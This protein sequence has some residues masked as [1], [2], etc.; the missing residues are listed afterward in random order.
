M[1]PEFLDNSISF[2]IHRTAMLLR[3]ELVR[4]LSDYHMTPEQWQVMATLWSTGDPLNQQDIVK[5]T[6]SDKHTV[7]RM[8]GRLEKNGWIKKITSPDDARVT[9]IK[10]TKKGESLKNEVPEKLSNYIK[11]KLKDLEKS[12][13]DKLLDILK[14][15][16]Y[17]LG[18]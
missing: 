1:I 12:D 17:V 7:S 9:I 18:D 13:K 14:K 5:L 16:R 10:P 2:N 11:E 3:R 6:L 15:L 8:I 4:A